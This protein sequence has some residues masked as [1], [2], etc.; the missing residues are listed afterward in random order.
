MTT[1]RDDRVR[2]VL[3]INPTQESPR[4]SE[5]DV[6]AL[7]DGRLLLA[8]SRFTGGS[9]DN[10][11]AHIA[12]RFSSDEG[13]TWG[14]D[15]VLLPREGEMNS[16]SV[17]L[18]RLASGD[19]AIFYLIKNSSR[20]CRLFMRTSRDEAK[21]WSEPICATPEP[22]YHV[23]NNA[24]V[25]QLS[26]GRLVVPAALHEWPSEGERIEP[27]RAM[28]FLSDDMGKTWHRSKTVLEPPPGSGSGLQE[29][30]VIE[31]K[32]GTLL[33]LC[34]TDLGAQY[35]SHSE[36]RGDTWSPAEPSNIV[37]PCSPATLRRIPGSGE[38]LMI[39]NDHSPPYSHL[40]QKRTPLAAAISRDEGKTWTGRRIL[41]DDPDGWFCYTSC[42]FI[43][44]SALLS[45]CAGGKDVG[46]LNRLRV[47]RIHTSWFL[48]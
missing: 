1:D 3:S 14:E 26:S 34:R 21:S 46:R 24:R 44:D 12:A 2:E 35:R 47:M 40:G 36:D 18:L 42:A 45:Y 9:G 23:V 10:S 29:P 13:R 7:R 11:A 39:W 25:V 38:L 4:N 19:L 33:M 15:Q 28:C 6:I 37:S 20:D 16:M 31:L 8:Y 41:E 5:G 27:G 48:Y 43:G 22:G 32:T 17:S 30:G